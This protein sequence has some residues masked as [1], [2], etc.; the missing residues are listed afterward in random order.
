MTR[1]TRKQRT[2]RA[3]NLKIA[4]EHSGLCPYLLHY[5]EWL[6][7]KGYSEGTANSR[8]ND[9]RRFIEWCDDRGIDD[10]RIVTK[11]MI[12]RY[13]RHL[14]YYRKRNGQPMGFGRQR[15]MLAAVKGWFKWLTQENYIPSNPASEVQSIKAPRKLPEKVLSIEE[16]TQVLCSVDVSTIEGLRNRAILEVLYST[17]IRRT[18]LCHLL[19]GDVDS[20]R[21]SVFV[22]L[23]KGSKDRCIPISTRAL[24]WVERYINES[25]VQL[26]VDVL[27]QG[28]FLN[29]YGQPVTS[30]YLG[31]IVKDILVEAGIERMGSCHLFR[32]A[33]ATHMLENGAELRYIQAILGH[34]NI[35]TTTIYTHLSIE[36]LKQVHADS[37]PVK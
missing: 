16:V 11:P 32:H 17:G 24:Q 30:S 23:G 27:E 9:L 33:M 25:R 36:K 29:A 22:R 15:A 14:Y 2:G 37:L 1:R 3:S 4:I 20:A 10:P 6:K 31:H 21:C 18:E 26:I 28:L 34:E 7:V 8:D 12:E 35:N 13:Q 19:V 5:V